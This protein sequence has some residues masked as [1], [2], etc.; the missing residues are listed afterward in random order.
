MAPGGAASGGGNLQIVI[1][2]DGARGAGQ[3]GV[4]IGEKKTGSAVIK[5]R[6]E[7]TVKSMASGAL[8]GSECRTSAGVRRI[9]G[10]LPVFEV[11]G[12]AFRRQGQEMGNCSA[13]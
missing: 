7:P 6:A 12:I 2:V 5:F 13:L 11:A 9:S 3:V 4:P 8:A 1:I 10:V